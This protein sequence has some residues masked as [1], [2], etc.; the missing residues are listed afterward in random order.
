MSKITI[1]DAGWTAIM[2]D[3]ELKRARSKLSFHEIRLIV[4]HARTFKRHD[5]WGA[6][7][8]GCPPEIKAGNGEICALLCKRCG[9]KSPRDNRCFGIAQ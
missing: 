7:E 3:P 9:V 5:F 8:P 6:G 2:A 4:D 1:E